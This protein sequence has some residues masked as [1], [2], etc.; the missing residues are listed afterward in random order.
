[1]K[2][3]LKKYLPK[4]ADYPNQLDILNNTNSEY[5]C[6]AIEGAASAY[7]NSPFLVKKLFFKRL[8][9]AINLI[10]KRKYAKVLDA[11]TGIGIMLPFLSQ[12]SEKVKAIDYTN[13]LDYARAMTKKR[14]I[15][16]VSF[17]KMDLANLKENEKFDLII[18]LS[19]LEHIE[20]TEKIFQ[21]FK[22]ILNEKGLLIVGYPIESNLMKLI[23]KLEA[24]IFR[25]DMSKE[26]REH[27][28]SKSEK[29]TGHISDWKKID[30][31]MKKYFKIDQNVNLSF[32]F[33]KYYALR[34][35]YKND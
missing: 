6:N 23:R 24:L 2:K 10:D 5:Y 25:K 13:I 4:K 33:F 17:E 12:V 30:N 3:S 32:C 31:S 20:D 34:K 19:V 28:Y 15:H 22:G 11:G 14:G 27:N 8:E 21:K 18:C 9:L 35:A 26:V 7:F 16:N 1:M 29:F